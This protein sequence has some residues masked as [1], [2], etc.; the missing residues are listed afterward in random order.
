MSGIYLSKSLRGRLVD[1]ISIINLNIKSLCSNEAFGW[2]HKKDLRV[3]NAA[4]RWR[5]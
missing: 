4:F 1:H 3:V 2:P 5:Y